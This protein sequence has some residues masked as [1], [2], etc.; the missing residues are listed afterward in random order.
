MVQ[1]DI[2]GAL[3]PA[4]RANRGILQ[5]AFNYAKDPVAFKQ[6]FEAVIQMMGMLYMK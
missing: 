6:C 2:I 5:K 1:P 4:E 3:M